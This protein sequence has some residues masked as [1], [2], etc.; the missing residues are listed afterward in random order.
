MASLTTSQIS[1]RFGGTQ[2]LHDLSLDIV[3][4]EFFFLLGPSG[5][6]KSTLLRII[7]GLERADSGSIEIDG[8]DV[9]KLPP[10]E[11]GIGMVFQHYALWPHMTIAQNITFGLENLRL[12]AAARRERML[13]SLSLVRME[14]FADRY[15]HQISGGQQQRV[16]LARALAMEPRI[17]LL[18]EPLSNLD[19]ALRQEI[20][21]ELLELHQRLNTT[22]VYVTHDQED[23]LALGSRIALLKEGRLK[24]LGSPAEIYAHPQ[25]AFAAR[26]LGDSNLLDGTLR[27]VQGEK[28]IVEID[29]H[30]G[31]EFV[32]GNLGS[33]A[34]P[35]RGALCVRPEAITVGRPAHATKPVITLPARLVHKS[36][37][38]ANYHVTLALE[39]GALIRSTVGSEDSAA[40]LAV[41]SSTTVSWLIDHSVFLTR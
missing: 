17:I 40:G 11:R 4:G 13:Q 2:I 15:P 5:C 20:R 38:G 36:F 30:R 3:S 41:G 9:T 1:K 18:D 22:M 28:L 10:Q 21:E 16:A 24:Q 14:D 6:G 34:E 31:G 27:S 23:A 7:A 33:G 39:G 37:R 19:A 32:A 35:G 25:S 8:R 12:S 29:A 26:F